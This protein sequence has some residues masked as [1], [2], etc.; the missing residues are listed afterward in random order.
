MM[1]PEDEP[2][3]SPSADSHSQKVRKARAGRGLIVFIIG[4]AVLALLVY[5]TIGIYAAITA[6]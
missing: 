2:G 6:T 3:L 1:R 5:I 4:I